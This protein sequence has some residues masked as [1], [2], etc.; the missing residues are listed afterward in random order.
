MV[1]RFRVPNTQKM[2]EFWGPRLG[3]RAT[4]FYA[5]YVWATFAVGPIGLGLFAT[6]GTAARTHNAA[7]QAIADAVIVVC[8]ATILVMFVTPVLARR[9]ASHT[10][11][12][13][14]NRRNHPPRDSRDYEMWCAR[15]GLQPYRADG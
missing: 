11:G 7:A 13:K 1:V 15:N 2:Y 12:V 6:I 4:G 9:A 3:S 5:T 14:I 10:L 8:G